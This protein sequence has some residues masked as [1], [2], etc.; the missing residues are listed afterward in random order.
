MQPATGLSFDLGKRVLSWGKGY[1]WNPV[2]F[3]QRSKDATDP[4][5]PREGYWMA[6]ATYVRS[7]SPDRLGLGLVQTVGLTLIAIPANGSVNQD[8]GPKSDSSVAGKLYLLVKDTD[9]DLMVLSGGARS[10]RYG[11][12]FSRNLG[13]RM[14]VHGEIARIAQSERPV[15][16]SQQQPVVIAGAST[17]YLLGLRYITEGDATILC[18]FYHNG[19]GFAAAEERAF[20]TLAHLAVE[21]GDP[22]LIERANRIAAAYRRPS[23]LRNYVNLKVS[24]N[25]A[26]GIVYFTPSLTAQANASDRSLLILPE[27]LYKGITN[28]ELRL[29]LQ[30]NVGPRETEFGEKTASTR[31]EF[32]MRYYF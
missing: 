24:Q 23:A 18:E 10:L 13:S 26:L 29:R 7:F 17:S 2:G 32:R 21:T 27:L 16:D 9:L 1:A 11:A 5:L 31:L 19:E 15:L 25:D 30:Q 6:D 22:A 8:F 28:L 3:V 4:N 12:D 20:F 14:E